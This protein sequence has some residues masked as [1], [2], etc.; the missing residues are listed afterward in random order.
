MQFTT[1]NLNHETAIA[2]YV[3]EFASAGEQEIHGYFGKPAWNHALTV[4][5]LDAWSHGRDLGDFEPLEVGNF[6]V[7]SF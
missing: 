1:L 2:D 5:K 7:K 6:Y 3:A 4:D